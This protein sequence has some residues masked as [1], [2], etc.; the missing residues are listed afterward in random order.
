MNKCYVLPDWLKNEDKTSLQHILTAYMQNHAQD[1]ANEDP[2]S[3][4][5]AMCKNPDKFLP[6]S[7]C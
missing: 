7:P 5:I 2:I 1:R 4:I 6:G 3:H